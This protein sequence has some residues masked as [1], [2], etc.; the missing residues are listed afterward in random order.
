MDKKR[1]R[2]LSTTSLTA[3]IIVVHNGPEQNQLHHVTMVRKT[4]RYD[5]KHCK[6]WL[7]EDTPGA[8]SGQE[9][10]RSTEPAGQVT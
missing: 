10:G 4:T 9:L 5:M 1:G 6:H 2:P 3:S 8:S 7:M